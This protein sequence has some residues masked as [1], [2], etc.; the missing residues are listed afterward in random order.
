MNF[1][2]SISSDTVYFLR[3]LWGKRSPWHV[4][5]RNELLHFE[6]PAHISVSPIHSLIICS[7]FPRNQFFDSAMR[8][9]VFRSN[10]LFQIS[11]LLF[12]FLINGCFSPIF[13][14]RVIRRHPISAPIELAIWFRP[15]FCRETLGIPASRASLRSWS[16]AWAMHHHHHAR[17]VAEIEM[18][19]R[20]VLLNSLSSPI[21]W[22]WMQ[23]ATSGDSLINRDG[24]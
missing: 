11:W 17:D 20:Y 2:A 5:R 6:F 13:F 4:K 1:S 18:L 21:P 10:K 23:R 14:F 22:Y 8:K 12:L 3:K 9:S 7:I 15:S 24:N 19:H 16:A